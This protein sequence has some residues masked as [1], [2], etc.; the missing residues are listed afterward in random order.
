ML[1][2]HHFSTFWATPWLEMLC[3]AIENNA[4]WNVKKGDFLKVVGSIL[5]PFLV[6]FFR[7]F[8]LLGDR[9]FRDEE[10]FFECH[11]LVDFG[12]KGQKMGKRPELGWWILAPD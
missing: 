1:F 5:A 6:P 12:T 9:G 3:F 7:H 11:F 2:W 4:F 8:S 10:A